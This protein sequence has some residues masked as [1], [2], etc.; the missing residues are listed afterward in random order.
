VNIQ[1]PTR[2]EACCILGEVLRDKALAQFKGES[3]AVVEVKWGTCQET[4]TKWKN[5]FQWGADLLDG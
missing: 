5:A 1:A 3:Y 2:E 4:D